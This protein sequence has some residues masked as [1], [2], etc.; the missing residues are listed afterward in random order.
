L[1]VIVSPPTA[2]APLLSVILS[3][4]VYV[5]AVVGV[6][7]STQY[8]LATPFTLDDDKANEKPGGSEPRTT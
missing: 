5:P 8:M 3:A 6:P 7:L 1:M 2:V 4:K